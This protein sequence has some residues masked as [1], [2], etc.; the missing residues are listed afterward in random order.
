MRQQQARERMILSAQP[1]K[2]IKFLSRYFWGLRV[3][4]DYICA[5]G[6]KD[7]DGSLR[8]CAFPKRWWLSARTATRRWGRNSVLLLTLCCASCLIIYRVS[9]ILVW[10]ETICGCLGR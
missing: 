9:L 8:S 2:V 10:L 6:Q 5:R 1:A 7:G 4:T 3:G